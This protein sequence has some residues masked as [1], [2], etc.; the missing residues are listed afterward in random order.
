MLSMVFW[1]PDAN[2]G[3]VCALVNYQWCWGRCIVRR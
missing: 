2:R 3:T 1:T